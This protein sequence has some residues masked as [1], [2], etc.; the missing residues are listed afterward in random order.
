MSRVVRFEDHLE[1]ANNFTSWKLRIMVMLK[2]NKLDSF[3]KEKKTK[4]ENGPENS[5]D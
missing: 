4:S 1:S 3:V 5:V 2:E